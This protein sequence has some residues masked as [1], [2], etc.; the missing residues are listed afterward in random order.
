MPERAYF[1][2]KRMTVQVSIDDG[3]DNSHNHVIINSA[4]FYLLPET[5]FKIAADKSD[6]MMRI[7][8]SFMNDR[9]YSEHEN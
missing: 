4:E 6:M 3:D 7:I 9:M 2:P 1:D 8:K 5:T